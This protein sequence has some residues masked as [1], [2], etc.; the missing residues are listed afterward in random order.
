[1][2]KKTRKGKT[3]INHAKTIQDNTIQNKTLYDSTRQDKQGQGNIIQEMTRKINTMRQ[4]K[5]I[6]GKTRQDKTKDVQSI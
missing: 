5:T 2:D 1:M 4:D 3:N 6:Y